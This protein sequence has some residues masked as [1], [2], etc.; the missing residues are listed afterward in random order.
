MIVMLSLLASAATAS[1]ECA[2][3]RWLNTPGE[4]WSVMGGFSSLE[5]CDAAIMTA[6]SRLPP[7]EVVRDKGFS[8]YMRGGQLERNLCLPDTVD[9]RG[10]KAGGR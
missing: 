8:S 7:Q 3:V 10:P 5:S 6:V 9:P 1:A 2:W 4:Q